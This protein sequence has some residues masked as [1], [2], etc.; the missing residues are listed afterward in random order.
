MDPAKSTVAVRPDG[1]ETCTYRDMIRRNM[2]DY[3]AWTWNFPISHGTLTATFTND[4]WTWL[5]VSRSERVSSFGSGFLVFRVG[6]GSPSPRRASR[7]P[8]LAV[9][10]DWAACARGLRLECSEP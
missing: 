5:L 4:L 2:I 9:T 1:P 3:D 8:A 6:M 10:I 7:G